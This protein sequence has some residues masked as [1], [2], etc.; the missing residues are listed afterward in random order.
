MF[1]KITSN[2]DPSASIG[3]E[4][5]KEFGAYFG[6]A[7]DAGKNFIM[8]Y[9]KFIFGA[10]VCLL[11]LSFSVSLFR[12]REIKHVP[13]ISVS[14]TATGLSQI[15]QASTAIRKTLALKRQVDSITGKNTLC[16]ADSLLLE[17]DLDSL[18]HIHQIFNQKP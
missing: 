14:P 8:C 18:Q 9:P 1:R 13:K 4:L 3:S 16:V 11:T 10:M 12:H 5:K 6:K 2:R 15:M 17:K 7:G